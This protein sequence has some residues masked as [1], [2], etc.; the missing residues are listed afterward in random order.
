[1]K[2][3]LINNEAPGDIKPISATDMRPGVLY[4]DTDGDVCLRPYDVA[5]E[6][7][8]LICFTCRDGKYQPLA[9]KLKDFQPRLTRIPDAY[10]LVLSN[11]PTGG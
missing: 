11:H 3:E 5:T 10:D 8:I 2:V 7:D 1:M 4:R 9:Y 6:N